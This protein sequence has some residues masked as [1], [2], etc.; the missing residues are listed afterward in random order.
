LSVIFNHIIMNNCNPMIR[1]LN[2]RIPYV[3]AVGLFIFTSG[4][5]GLKVHQINE[6]I[7]KMY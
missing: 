4:F 7:F 1:Y 6:F 5:G 2:Q 3:W